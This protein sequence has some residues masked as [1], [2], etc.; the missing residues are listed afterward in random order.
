MIDTREAGGGSYPE[1]PYVPE[2]DVPECEECY[3]TES[4]SVIDGHRLCPHCKADYIFRH[5]DY[6]GYMRFIRDDFGIQKDFF[7]DWYFSNLSKVDKLCAAKYLFNH[8]SDNT[9]FIEAKSYVAENKL[10][11]AEFM[12]AHDGDV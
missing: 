9:K 3:E 8:E 6:D 1:P 11:F 4:L 2:P 5:A 7:L 10:D 12:E